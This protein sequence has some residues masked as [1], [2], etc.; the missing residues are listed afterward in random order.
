MY[1]LFSH[2]ALVSA[3]LHNTTLMTPALFAVR[4][5]LG[6]T[7]HVWG[8]H[9]H[10]ARLLVPTTVL[11]PFPSLSWWRKCVAYATSILVI[12]PS[13]YG[14][15]LFIST[16]SRWRSVLHG[17]GMEFDAYGPPPHRNV[18]EWM[19]AV[20]A[21]WQ[22]GMF[23]FISRNRRT[24]VAVHHKFKTLFAWWWLHFGA[25]GPPLHRTVCN[26]RWFVKARWQNG[27]FMLISQ[28]WTNRS[29]DMVSL[30]LL[31]IM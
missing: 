21:S 15:R 7:L 10:A 12:H 19:E 22:E 25:Y 23:I 8:K 27:T 29:C 30:G 28:K 9:G 3:D 26:W 11:S 31:L 16:L 5:V 24:K 14:W 17:D 2:L 13:L 20:A 18:T 6:G 4:L 1:C